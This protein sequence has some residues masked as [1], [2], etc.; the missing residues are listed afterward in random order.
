M[1]EKEQSSILLVEDD[2]GH[3]SL[4]ARAFRAHSGRFCL[5][6]AVNLQEARKELVEAQP[7]LV[8]TDL[9]LPDG[10]GIELLTSKE[11]DLPYPIVV[12]T[13]H[14][15]EQVAV[16]AMKA[17]A[18]DYVVKSAATLAA[19]PR[20]AERV[21]R[22]WGHIVQRREA[23]KNLA[24]RLRLEEA[25]AQCSRALLTNSPNAMEEAVSHLLKATEIGS[26]C[27]F[28][29]I[30]DPIEGLC[31]HLILELHNLAVPLPP[32]T[33][34]GNSQTMYIPYKQGFQRWQEKLGKGEAIS[35]PVD[36]FPV[37]EQDLL[38]KLA[39]SMAFMLILPLNIKS[40]WQGFISFV[41]FQGNPEWSNESI[42][43]LQVSAEMIGAYLG[44]KQTEKMLVKA[45]DLLEQRVIERTAELHKA[46][47]E[48]QRDI[49]R[50][51]QA[52]DALQQ[53]EERYRTLVEY[54]PGAIVVHSKGRVLYVN[55]AGV[56]L[57]G[58]SSAKE[59]AERPLCEFVHSDYKEDVIQRVEGKFL[60]FDGQEIDVEIISAPIRYKNEPAVQVL[61][62][63]IT[64]RK[65]EEEELKRAKEIA[66]AANQAKNEFVA[67]MSHEIRT[68]M[69][70][71]IGMTWLLQETRLNKQQRGYIDAIHKSG[72]A[73][74]SIIDD[75]LDFSKIEAGKLEMDTLDF[76]LRTILQDLLDLH[77]LRMKKKGLDVVFRI[78]PDVQFFL[79]GDP[80]RLRQV[81]TN[82]IGNA[83]KFTPQG[84]IT[85]DV[86]L[87]SETDTHVTIRFSISDT[88][89]GIPRDRVNNL[90]DKFTQVDA[91]MSRKYGGTGLGLAISK[92]LCELMG[93]QIGVTSEEGKGSTF[94]FTAVFKKQPAQKE[95]NERWPAKGIQGMRI[96]V[97]DANASR[98]LMLRDQLHLWNCRYD[99]AVDGPS[100]LKKMQEAAIQSNSYDVAILDMPMPGMDL[101]K[102]AKTIKNN[103]KLQKTFLIM[104]TSFG[105][106]DDAVRLKQNGFAA[107]LTQPVTKEELYECLSLVVN[108]EKGEDRE[109]EKGTPT[110]S[111]IARR[112][113]RDTRILLAED[114][115]INRK[116]AMKILEKLGYSVD[117]VPDGK[118][119]VRVLEK[120]SYDLVLMDIQMP[121]MD[122]YEATRI[123]RNPGSMVRDHHIPIVALTANTMKGDREKCIAAGMDDYVGK[124]I[125]PEELV[126]AIER[127]LDR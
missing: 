97:V 108:R 38:E 16:D 84:N 14:G 35:G 32:T 100:A 23:E 117:A 124:P 8:L 3:A 99:E 29:N 83:I 68:P 17:G 27:V 11:K 92:R 54:S 76:D 61:F 96:L 48:L 125:K 64:E 72:T 69:N 49:V 52:E 55:P 43:I 6:V 7:D 79:Q 67:N 25:L 122:G 115:L 40:S 53:S 21:L 86:A 123:I 110:R 44:L 75:I 33:A 59:F 101:V 26:I 111:T 113:N 60:R 90:F 24:L 74:L 41:N 51:K 18:L 78:G 28:E 87:E 22:E 12:L 71:I 20:I 37:K 89:I 93:G 118:E 112:K 19:M 1:K 15:D 58:A 50:R 4:I 73:L 98:R 56:K 88:G 36:S 45:R 109:Q 42:R 104:M 46:N 106:R 62:R 81:L 91:S 82:L 63:D 30:E 107:C 102:M 31:M 66:E 119:A 65:K 120:A 34:P 85:L 57:F 121:E 127:N 80:G 70:G 39:M 94:W 10:K 9:M 95:L 77:S 105:K 5:K 116:V 13:S 126:Q 2:P 103:P 114:N 47:K